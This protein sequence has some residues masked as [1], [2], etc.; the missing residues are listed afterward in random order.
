MATAL[1]TFVTTAQTKPIRL[2][3]T[4]M[5]TVLVMFVRAVAV[6]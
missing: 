4:P 3:V 2:K 1:V 6:P 5:A